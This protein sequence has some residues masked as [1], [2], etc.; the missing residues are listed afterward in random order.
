MW[1]AVVSGVFAC[2]LG[3]NACGGG[4]PAARGFGSTQIQ[5]IRDSTLV[6][7]GEQGPGVIVYGTGGPGGGA[8]ASANYWTLNLSTGAVQDYGSQYPPSPSS[9]PTPPSPYTCTATSSLDSGILT[10]QIVDNDTGT[11]TDIDVLSHARCPGEDGNFV[12]V[13]PGPSGFQLSMGPF[14][15]LVPVPLPLQIDSVYWWGFDTVTN[16]PTSVT[17]QGALPSAPDAIGVYTVDLSSS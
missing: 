8:P 15:Q 16:A 13:V 17:V 4:Q 5:P 9:T 2:A 14:T 3:A 11:E 1:R 7:E 12:A 6:L 10:L